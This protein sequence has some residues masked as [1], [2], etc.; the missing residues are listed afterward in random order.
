MNFRNVKNVKGTESKTGYTIHITKSQ[1][2]KFN[3]CVKTLKREFFDECQKNC[4]KT[5]KIFKNRIKSH[6]KFKGRGGQNLLH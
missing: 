5:L 2:I 4:Y 3:I 6:Q 1:R